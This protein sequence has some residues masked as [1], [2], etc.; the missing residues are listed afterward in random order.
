MNAMASHMIRALLLCIFAAGC[1]ESGPSSG[2]A[3]VPMK[4]GAKTYKLEIANTESSRRTGLMRRDSMPADHGMIF[5]FSEE[6]ILQF[7]MLNTRIPLDILFL[8]TGGQI[9]SVHEMKA[10]DTRTETRSARPAKYAIELNL[11]QIKTAGV[12]PGDVLQ[13]PASAREPMD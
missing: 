11:G 3:T 4:I 5:S 2:L 10:Y 1:A 8:D 9:V 7:H 13:I 12:K 6:Q